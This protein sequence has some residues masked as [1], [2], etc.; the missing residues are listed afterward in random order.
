MANKSQVRLSLSGKQMTGF[1]MDEQ[2]TLDTLSALGIGISPRAMKVAMD[3]YAMDDGPTSI[4][5]QTVSTPI[6]FLQHFL[7]D[8]IRVVT[9]AR[10]IDEILGMDIAGNWSDEELVAMV[11]E[12]TGQTR[13]YGDK[14]NPGLVSFNPNFERRT[15][16]R[17]ENAI[18]VSVLEEERASAMRLNSASE[19]RIAS[20]TS[21]AITRNIVG[22]SGYNDGA[23]RTYGLLNDPNLPVYTTVASGVGGTTWAAKTFDEMTKDII[24]AQN[25]LLVRSG[26]NYDPYKDASVLVVAHVAVGSLAKVNSLGTTSVKQWIAQTYPNCR[27]EVAPQ[28]SAANGGANVFY[29]MAESINGRKVANQYVQDVYRMLGVQRLAK[30]FLEAFSCATA[31][32]LIAQPVGVVRYSG[33]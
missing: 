15:I 28:F 17:F 24:T 6:Q 32:V 2:T 27:I 31:G 18:E 14:A 22:F 26:A 12:Q 19:K 3:S 25:A 5:A 13:P 1:A 23:N 33:I 16:V 11:I 9:Q 30:G 29:L 20:A 4:T 10:K 21:F 7:A 8:P